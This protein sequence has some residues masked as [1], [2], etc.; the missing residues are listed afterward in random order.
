MLSNLLNMSDSV[1]PDHERFSTMSHFFRRELRRTAG[2][3]HGQEGEGTEKM[4]AIICEH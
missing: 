4:R 1:P 2:N 3:G